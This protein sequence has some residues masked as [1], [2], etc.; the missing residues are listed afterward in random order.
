MI[1]GLL[2]GLAWI[3]ASVAV[4]ALVTGHLWTAVVVALTA[5]ATGTAAGA[6]ADDVSADD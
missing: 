4:V 6:L 5:I 2:A 1:A 3:W